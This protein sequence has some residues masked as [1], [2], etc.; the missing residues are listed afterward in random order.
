M[1]CTHVQEQSCN[2]KGARHLHELTWVLR[3]LTRAICECDVGQF[4]YTW[5][6]RNSWGCRS[7]II[8]NT[9]IESCTTHFLRYSLIAVCNHTINVGVSANVSCLTLTYLWW[10]NYRLVI[11]TGDSNHLINCTT[12]RICKRNHQ[13]ECLYIICEQ[14]LKVQNTDRNVYRKT[15]SGMCLQFSPSTSWWCKLSEPRNVSTHPLNL[16]LCNNY[17]PHPKDGEDN[18]FTLVWTQEAHRTWEGTQPWLSREGVPPLASKGRS[19]YLGLGPDEGGPTLGNPPHPSWRGQ[20]QR[21][22]LPWGARSPL[23][24]VPTLAG[25]TTR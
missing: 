24:M 11:A 10:C 17:R 20:W 1:V 18:S 4:N 21:G 5:L 23:G 9:S 22:Y 16:N 6:Y 13:Q 8:M 7:R 2:N 14:A 25:G 12:I 15:Q 3:R 19:T